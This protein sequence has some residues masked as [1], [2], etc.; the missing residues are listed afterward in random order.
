MHE[1]SGSEFFRTST[2]IQS[3][4]AAFRWIK[5]HYDLFN[6]FERHANIMSYTLVPK[7][8]TGNETTES[9]R[10]EFSEKLI[11]HKFPWSDAAD[12]TSGAFNRGGILDLALLRRVLE[13]CL[14]L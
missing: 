10:L 7:G 4:P 5:V 12:N 13:I 6:H 9:S 3:G 11:A 2:R 8:K 1:I 14:N